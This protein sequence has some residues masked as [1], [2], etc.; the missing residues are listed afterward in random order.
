MCVC[1]RMCVCGSNKK[2]GLL[3]FEKFSACGGL[4]SKKIPPAAGKFFNSV[5]YFC[6]FSI[7]SS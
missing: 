6:T 2:G 1:V 4:I 5:C 3:T 7:T